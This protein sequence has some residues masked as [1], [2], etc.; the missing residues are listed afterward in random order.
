MI[1]ENRNILIFL[2]IKN[3]MIT[4]IKE[5]ESIKLNFSEP[6]TNVKPYLDLLD[7]NEEDIVLTEDFL[8]INKVVKLHF[9]DESV[10]SIFKK[11]SLQKTI[12]YFKSFDIDENFITNYE[13][14]KK[15]GSRFGKI[16]F[17]VENNKFF[18]ETCDKTNMY[19]NKVK[20]QISNIEQDDL[21][22]CFDYKGFTNVMG[23]IDDIS[24]FSI[25]FSYVK[26]NKL[27]LLYIEKKD[28]SEKYFLMS[29]VE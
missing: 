8:K 6:N 27:G 13:K 28:L 20:Y 18:I 16:Y 17:S 23:L 5:N 15:I 7:N 29:L 19:S 21:S 10:I 24:N 2:N 14:I 3:E 11:N 25:K 22:L 4:G 26:E 1:S 9:D 12:E